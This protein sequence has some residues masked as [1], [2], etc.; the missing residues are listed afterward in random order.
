ML[1]LGAEEVTLFWKRKVGKEGCLAAK[2]V[3]V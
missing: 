3:E 2:L 1:N